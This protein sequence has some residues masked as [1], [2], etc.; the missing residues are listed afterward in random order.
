MEKIR[1]AILG[2]TGYTGIELV[3]L[4]STHPKFF[5]HALISRQHQGVQ[6]G[7]LYSHLSGLS[8]PELSAFEDTDFSKIDLV[9]CALPH[10]IS[11]TLIPF[12]P[13][14]VRI[15]DLSSDFRLESAFD[16]QK[17]Y[18]TP[19]KTRDLQDIAVFGI[20]ELYKEKIRKTRLVACAGCYVTSALIPLVPL[21]VQDVIKKESIV[22][23][24]KSGASGAGKKLKTSSLFCEVTNGTRAYNVCNHRHM[25]ELDQELKKAAGEAVEYRFVPH[26]V[27]QSRGILSTIYVTGEAERI[28]DAWNVS[29]ADKPFIRI[30]PLN[31]IPQ[32]HDVLGSNT[33]HMGVVKDR[34]PDK[35]IIVST[36]DNLIKGASG[37]AIQNANIMFDLDETTGLPLVAM[38][39]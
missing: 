29:Y 35:S 37:Q 17:W 13:E 14:H 26:I 31:T 25:A 32:T 16:F 23:D 5:L 9:F 18:G 22:I 19:P 30:L 27:P 24:S 8:L 21:L 2:A 36:I 6:L 12:L 34:N 4:L 3:R 10:G 7:T 15:V 28:L 11:Q 38:F 39:P 1:T 33:I 20:S